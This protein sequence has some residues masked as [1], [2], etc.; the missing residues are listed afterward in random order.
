MKTYDD[1]CATIGHANGKL[2]VGSECPR[3]G[4]RADH[5]TSPCTNCL[6]ARILVLESWLGEAF[7]VI[8]KLAARGPA[9]GLPVER[10]VGE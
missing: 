7:R 8:G 6:A 1:Q 5:Y 2:L 10:E 9:E 4:H 3:C